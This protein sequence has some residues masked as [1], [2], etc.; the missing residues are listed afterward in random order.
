M[1]IPITLDCSIVA[2]IWRNQKP[3]FSIRFVKQMHHNTYIMYTL[4]KLFHLWFVGCVTIISFTVQKY[5][6]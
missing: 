3:V 2:R 5:L 1:K 6:K 4:L